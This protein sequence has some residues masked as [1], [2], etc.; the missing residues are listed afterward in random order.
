MRLLNVV[1]KVFELKVI[2]SAP[3]KIH[4]AGEHSVVYGGIA[5]IAPAEINGKRN[6]VQLENKQGKPKIRFVGKGFG[7]TG[8]AT[9]YPNGE[10]KG[11]KVWQPMLDV[12]QHVL[13]DCGKNLSELNQAIVAERFFSGAPKGTG[14]SASI[15]AAFAL[16][17]Y[18]FFDKKPTKKELFEAAFVAD[19]AWHGGKSSGGDVQAVIS[20]YPQ[21]FWRE[22]S[23]GEVKPRFED[24]HGTLPENTELVLADS[25]KGVGE[26]ATTALQ[27]EK[28]AAAHQITKK[29]VE[30]TEKERKEICKPFNEII[31]KMENEM[32]SN[33]NPELL[34]EL[35]DENHE[36][37]RKSGVSSP[38]I[39]EVVSTSKKNGALGA[40]LVGAGGVGGAVIALCEKEKTRLITNALKQKGFNTW[41][42]KF[43][44]KGACIDNV[45]E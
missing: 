34:G 44:E 2:A 36:L 7:E 9:L 17:L 4:F 11:D 43:A 5:L 22:F 19:N 45:E 1:L 27:I 13:N 31:E 23:R 29:P 10:R 38:E 30:L 35:M 6:V 33:G 12:A 37:L 8:E 15:P 16:A 32:R 25:Y 14:N 24:F 39:E 40:K 18:E 21:K 42:V 41:I 3:N 20:N 26:K 28:F